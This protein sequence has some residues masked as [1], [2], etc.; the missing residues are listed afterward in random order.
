MDPN[1]PLTTGQFRDTIWAVALG[2]AAPWVVIVPVW[3][4]IERWRDR[5][6]SRDAQARLQVW[7]AAHPR[8]PRDARERLWQIR[9]QLWLDSPDPHVRAYILR[10]RLEDAEREARAQALLEAEQRGNAH[11][12]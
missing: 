11:G 3:L 6:A 5:R 12:R 9:D 10:Q 4:L 7:E 8:A 1:A 2:I